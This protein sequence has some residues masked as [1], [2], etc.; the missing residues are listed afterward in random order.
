MK[1]KI[2][3]DS[4]AVNST[5]DVYIGCWRNIPKNCPQWL[6][7]LW[8]ENQSTLVGKCKFSGIQLIEL[9][10][11]GLDVMIVRDNHSDAKAM[12]RIIIW[13]DDKRFMRV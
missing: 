3:P 10:N 8:N 2:Y 11:C 6:L 13:V 7:D 9:F 1:L 12:T 4:I 5:D